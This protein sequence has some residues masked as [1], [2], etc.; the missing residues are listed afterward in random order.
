MNCASLGRFPAVI[1]GLIGWCAV[2]LISSSL[3]AQAKKQAADAKPVVL[4]PP[5][6]NQSKVHQK[7][8]YE[9]GTGS[10]EGLPLRQFMVDRFTEAP[11]SILE[12]LLTNID[13]ITVVERQR[14]DSF[15]VETEFGAMSGFVDQEKAVKLGKLL[16]A[17]LIVMGTITDLHEDIRDFQGYGVKSRVTD[18]QCQIRVRLLDIASGTVRFSKIVKGTKTYTK[19]SFGQTDTSDRGFAAVEAALEKLADD[20]QFKSALLGKKSGAGAGEMVEVEFAPKPD[21]CDIEIDGKY[22]GGSPLKRKLPA[23]KDIKVRITKDGYKDWQGVISP[24]DGL[25]ITRELGP[26]R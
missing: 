5:F 23:G 14:I 19:S 1:V 8:A 20:D 2:M 24:E 12:D 13:G 21:N 22:V 25:K 15:L 3:L 6:E 17:N 11:R 4:V 10:N 26:S 18:V 9:V 16:G 7:M